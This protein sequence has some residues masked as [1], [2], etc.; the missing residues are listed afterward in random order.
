MA[1]LAWTFPLLLFASIV[2]GW[3]AE[4]T[5][6]H[7][8][9]GIALAVLAWLQTAPEFAVEASIAWARDTHLALANLTG[10]LR[11]LMGLGWP[12]VFFVHWFSQR[13]R[14]SR[15]RDVQLP[16][17]FSIE[18][19]SLAVPVIYFLIILAKRTW[20][21]ADGLILCAFYGAYFWLLYRQRRSGVEEPAE[22]HDDE[23]RIV[24]A[25]LKLDKRKQYAW[26][27]F[28][29]AFGAWALLT[30]VHPFVDALKEVAT[31][32]GVSQFVFIQWVAPIASEFPEK[33]TAFNWA[34]RPGKASMAIV[35]MLSSITSQWT[36][37]AGLVPVIFSLSAGRPFTIALSAFQR[38][39]LAL[40]VAQSALAVL[41]LADLKVRAYEVAGLFVLW[42]AQFV[43]PSWREGL[44]PIYVFWTV[45]EAAALAMN[46]QRL[47][48]WK[49][50]RKIIFPASSGRNAS[51]RKAR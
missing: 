44:I 36:L 21:L 47:V 32:L 37:L 27:L 8:S 31:S 14:G 4:I 46:P 20:T 48:A 2:I 3:A 40:T 5:A 6:A 9:A 23:P 38:A 7:L 25:V 43:M 1:A 15:V 28:M 22:S 39:E 17:S 19:V 33:V 30:C 18:A 35:N 50:L 41:F 45:L 10:S 12:M 49:T 51:A 42:L 26:M 24:R 11:L 16:A 13:Q 34:R 29:F